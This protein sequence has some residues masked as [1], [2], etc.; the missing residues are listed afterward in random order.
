MKFACDED[1]GCQK[2]LLTK[3]PAFSNRCNQFAQQA[4]DQDICWDGMGISIPGL[5]NLQRRQ[6]QKLVA[7]WLP[8]LFVL[9]MIGSKLVC[10]VVVGVEPCFHRSNKLKPR[11]M[12]V[13]RAVVHCEQIATKWGSN[14]DFQDAVQLFRP[15]LLIFSFTC[16]NLNVM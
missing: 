2:L 10:C 9:L 16:Y 13:S 4:S 3:L 11:F 15:T 14:R 5:C 1:V 8:L 6:R 7:E 12:G